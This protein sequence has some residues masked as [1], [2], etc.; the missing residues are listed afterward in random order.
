M[1]LDK[2]VIIQGFVLGIRNGEITIDD[3]P[4]M[5]RQEVLEYDEE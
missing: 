3:V 2:K 5:Y 1:T 4:E